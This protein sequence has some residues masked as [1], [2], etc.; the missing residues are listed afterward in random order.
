MQCVESR[1]TLLRDSTTGTFETKKPRMTIASAGKPSQKAVL[2]P[3]DI[4]LTGDD[5]DVDHQVLRFICIYTHCPS[6]HLHVHFIVDTAGQ[7][8]QVVM[9][10]QV[11]RALQASLLELHNLAS[12][13]LRYSNDQQPA[14]SNKIKQHH[15]HIADATTPSAIMNTAAAYAAAQPDGAR[16]AHTPTSSQSAT[17]QLDDSAA[18]A[19][20]LQEAV[21][22]ASKVIRWV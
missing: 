12:S 1:A 5:T 22:P 19:T 11:Q 10:L 8:L 3:V 14:E 9:C 20:Q 21:E 13:G 7:Y 6:P 2:K 18:A 17:M 16:A 4:D 15:S